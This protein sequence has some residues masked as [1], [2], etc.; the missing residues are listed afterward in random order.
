VNLTRRRLL[1]GLG[2]SA[3]LAPFV[4][5]LQ[6]EAEAGGGMPK[7]L[8]LFF[9]PHGTIRENW[10]PQG[11]QDAFT[12]PTILEPLTPHV[13][14]ITVVDGLTIYPQGP[15]GGPHTVGP[16][17]LFTGSRMQD[18]SE[19]DHGCCTPHGW[20]TTAS[21]DQ[22][23]AEAVGK[24]S[25]YKSL[26]FGVRT[27]SQFPGARIS[28]AGPA[29]PLPPERDPSAMF[30]RLFGDWSGDP[31][32]A[33]RL[34]AERLG[35]LDAVGP[36]LDSLMTKVGPDDRVKIEAHAD[37]VAAL[38]HRLQLQHE[39]TVPATPAAMDSNLQANVPELSRLQ[40]DLMVEALACGLTNVASIMYRVGEN[41]NHPYP[42]LGISQGHHELSHA[43]DS[44]TAARASLTSIYRWYAEEFA[45]LVDRMANIVEADGSRLLDNTLIVWGSEI[46]IGNTHA[47]GP[48]PFVL[49]GGCGGSIR[50]G[51]FITQDGANHCRLLTTICN[52]MGLAEV[53]SFGNLDDGAGPL[54]GLLA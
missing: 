40:L 33:A 6:R 29:Q 2:V 22:V 16:A 51:R 47:W 17:Y 32:Q 18:G 36:E 7:R 54:G 10:L 19:F 39:C 49:A 28:Y 42:W 4:P 5:M 43:G 46:G 24:A 12:L 37:A 21:V 31:Q 15:V 35:I 38:Q 50:T 30:D 25:A 34:K 53:E 45:Y 20:N 3:G 26:E 44:D 9:H 41:D 23:V 13:A 48:M 8:V 27:G 1:Q 14:D 11:T 52:A